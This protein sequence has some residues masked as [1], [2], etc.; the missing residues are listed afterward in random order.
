MMA[1]A[2]AANPRLGREAVVRA[3]G[4]LLRWLK[5]HPSP[6]PEPIYLLVTL[7]TAPVRRFE[8]H[9]SL[10]LSPF[11]SIFLVADR[12][13]DDLPDDIETLPSS[14]LRSLPAVAR[15][16]LVLV[17]SRLKIPGSGKGAK[18]RGRVVPVDLADPAWAESAR[19]AARRVELRVEAG[20][21]RAVRVGHAA[22]APAELVENVVAAVEAAA[23]CVPRKWRNVRALHLKAPESIALPLYAAPGTGGNDDPKDAKREGATAVEQRRVKRRR[24]E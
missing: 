20:T 19:E 15:R 5:H 22:M 16:G 10:P 23:A 1:S 6:A 8:H 11:P 24:N 7:K 13:P 12:L 14:A 17:D 21:C 9:L 3:V 2:P 4:A 18:G